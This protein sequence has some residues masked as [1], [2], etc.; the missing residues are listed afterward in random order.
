[1]GMMDERSIPRE[2]ENERGS[3][4]EYVSKVFERKPAPKNFICKCKIS[5]LVGI[6]FFVPEF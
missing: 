3:S 1:M 4:H 6:Q 2:E 5:I